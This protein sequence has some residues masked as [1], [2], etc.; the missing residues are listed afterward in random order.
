MKEANVY[1]RK[2]K[3]YR[4]RLTDYMLYVLADLQDDL[5]GN[6]DVEFCPWALHKGVLKG[7][8]ARG[9][10]EPIPWEDAPSR[11]RYDEYVEFVLSK[12]RLSDRGALISDRARVERDF[13]PFLGHNVKTLRRRVRK[14]KTKDKK[15]VAR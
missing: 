12:L 9:E 6:I 11:T 14:T 5:E 2:V 3:G 1:D 4:I 15:Q 13:G 7:L 10:I 8:E